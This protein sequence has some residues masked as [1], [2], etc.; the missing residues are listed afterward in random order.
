MSARR[1]PFRN[2]LTLVPEVEVLEGL[3]FALARH[4]L[5]DPSHEWSDVADTGTIDV[6]VLD[7]GAVIAAV[8]E[9]AAEAR[10]EIEA[11]Y[12]AVGEALAAALD[13]SPA[14]AAERLITAGAEREE[15]GRY[16]AALRFFRAAYEASLPIGDRHAEIVALRRMGRLLISSGEVA[17]AESCYRRSAELAHDL[18]ETR[19]EVIARTGLGNVYLRTGQSVAAEEA[20]REAL[21]LVEASGG[22]GL[23]KERAQLMNNLAQISVM[24]G[25]LDEA[26]DWIRTAADLW[27][28]VHSPTDFAVHNAASAHVAWAEGDLPRARDSYQ[29]ALDHDPPD[30]LRAAYAIDLAN[31]YLELGDVTAARQYGREAEQAALSAGSVG[32]LTEVYRGL[33]NIARDSGGEPVALYEKSLEIARKNGLRLSEAETLIDYARLQ[34]ATGNEE[35]GRAFLEYAVDL[36]DDLGAAADARRAREELDRTPAME[37]PPPSIP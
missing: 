2:L 4:A 8:A 37:E 26:H 17:Q 1:L 20:Y 32:Y 15:N 10:Q 12:S 28:K 31:V 24:M 29:R 27:Q 18:G 34:R 5:T 35:E 16:T 6:R 19:E 13:G 21:A 25:R 9:A 30:L 23:E 3:R 7:R 33:G 14:D 11:I 22:E 36:L